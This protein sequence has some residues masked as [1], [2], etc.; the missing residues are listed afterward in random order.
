LL[1]YPIEEKETQVASERACSIRTLKINIM[2]LMI[3]NLVMKIIIK[4]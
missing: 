2:D 4:I 3:T 1:L